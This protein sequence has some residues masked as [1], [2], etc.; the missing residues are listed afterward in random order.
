MDFFR[1]TDNLSPLYSHFQS[2]YPG[3]QGIQSGDSSINRIFR[4]DFIV[5]CSIPGTILGRW[6]LIGRSDLVYSPS[7]SS[8]LQS[9]SSPSHL[10]TR[11]L[12]PLG[13]IVLHLLLHCIISTAVGHY[14]H[15]FA[16]YPSYDCCRARNLVQSYFRVGAPLIAQFAGLENIAPLLVS[17]TTYL[18]VGLLCSG[19]SYEPRG[20]ASV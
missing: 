2:V 18:A 6:S 14:T 3:N 1:Y 8:S 9:S 12:V 4:N 11:R 16:M 7:T 5:C 15:D 13:S 10:L 19:F 17:A 20:K